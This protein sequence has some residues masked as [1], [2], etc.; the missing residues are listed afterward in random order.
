MLLE[1]AQFWRGFRVTEI[2]G[3]GIV[4][5]WEVCA[6]WAASATVSAGCLPG[7]RE[8]V[9]KRWPDITDEEARI[10][11]TLGRKREPQPSCVNLA[12]GLLRSIPNGSAVVGAVSNPPPR[13]PSSGLAGRNAE[14]LHALRLHG[15]LLRTPRP[16]GDVHVGLLALR[17]ACL[18]H[19]RAPE[20]HLLPPDFV[21]LPSCRPRGVGP[22][23]AVRLPARRVCKNRKLRASG[24]SNGEAEVAL[25]PKSARHPQASGNRTR[26]H[27]AGQ[28]EMSGVVVS[29]LHRTTCNV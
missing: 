11:T 20:M 14:V 7:L 3:L 28:C 22:M 2:K 19:G 26:R 13:S 24:K 6:G 1:A 23:C 15:E 25:K 9:G 16:F 10:Q 27:V 4:V 5:D 17:Q 21:A 29:A 18:L 8:R 12:Q